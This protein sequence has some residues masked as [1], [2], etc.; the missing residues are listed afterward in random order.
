MTERSSD[1]GDVIVFV[2]IN[3]EP[4]G[5]NVRTD[6]TNQEGLCVRSRSNFRLTDQFERN[7]I[8]QGNRRCSLKKFFGRQFFGIQ[9]DTPLR[10][11][12]PISP[13]E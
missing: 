5:S 6:C 7:S 2:R 8:R 3:L 9:N 1:D 12:Q 10:V 11:V 4:R 13:F